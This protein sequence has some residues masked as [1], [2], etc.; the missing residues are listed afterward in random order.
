M[1]EMDVLKKSSH[2]NIMEVYEFLE[3]DNYYYIVSELLEGGELNARVAKIG[4]YN[5]KKAAYILK[6]ILMAVNYL[7]NNNVMHRD[8]KGS[9]I[10][11]V[12]D[13]LDCIDVK[14]ADFGFSAAFD[15]QR[16]LELSIGTL[17]YEAPEILQRLR[18][19]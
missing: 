13:D 19:S 12:S 2:P 6:Q 11:L 9:N 16:G 14:L 1:Q 17:K 4:C 18:Y 3:D 8:L 10:L 5:E 15:P 7:H